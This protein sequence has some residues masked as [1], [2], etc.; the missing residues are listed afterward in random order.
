M[1]GAMIAHV[2]WQQPA[3]GYFSHLQIYILTCGTDLGTR[4][5]FIHGSNLIKLSKY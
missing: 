2:L 3:G 5:V 1:F 4:F